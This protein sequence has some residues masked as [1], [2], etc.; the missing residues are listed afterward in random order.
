MTEQEETEYFKSI[1]DGTDYPYDHEAQDARGQLAAIL[2]VAQ[3]DEFQKECSSGD[4]FDN[5]RE[6]RGEGDFETIEAFF[7]G[8][9]GW[10][11]LEQLDAAIAALIRIGRARSVY[12][13]SHKRAADEEPEWHKQH[14]A[15]CKQDEQKK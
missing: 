14:I 12:Y 10:L 15:Q 2:N 4:L 8:L 6:G 3:F 9:L 5:N 1:D 11:T 13:V 7:E